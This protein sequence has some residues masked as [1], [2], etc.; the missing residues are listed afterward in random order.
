VRLTGERSPEACAISS[1]GTKA[2]DFFVQR[3]RALELPNT[4]KK[5]RLVGQ[6]NDE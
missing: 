5:V 3:L 6:A 1:C 2:L 4:C